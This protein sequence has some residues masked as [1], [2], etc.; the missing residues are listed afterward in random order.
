VF[1]TLTHSTPANIEEKR[2]TTE[3]AS[4]LAE[5]GN[6]TLAESGDGVGRD[7]GGVVVPTR[8]SCALSPAPVS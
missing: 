2:E 7:S 3:G 8:C 5:P 4:T 1:P 6:S